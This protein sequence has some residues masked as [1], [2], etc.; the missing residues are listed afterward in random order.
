MSQVRSVLLSDHMM[1]SG[2]GFEQLAVSWP[3]Q[4]NLVKSCKLCLIDKA[5]QKEV[6]R[7]GGCLDQRLMEVYRGF[8][9]GAHPS[10][11][12]KFVGRKF[13]TAA[14]LAVLHLQSDS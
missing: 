4:I 7:T 6:L 10:S 8:F 13:S 5:W 14:R 12:V 9:G 2:P 1:L 11:P 3:G